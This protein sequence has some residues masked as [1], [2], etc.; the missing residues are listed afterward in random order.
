MNESWSPHNN[1]QNKKIDDAFFNLNC[2]I[3]QRF[4]GTS[5]FITRIEM[6]QIHLRAYLNGGFNGAED[7]FG[8]GKGGGRVC[9]GSGNIENFF[10]FL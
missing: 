3:W 10:N 1:D 5:A 8:L 9:T 4:F 2:I 7:S 6:G